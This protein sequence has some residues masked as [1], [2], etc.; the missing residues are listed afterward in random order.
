MISSLKNKLCVIAFSL[1]VIVGC[2]L[3][4]NNFAE[5]VPPKYTSD[6]SSHLTNSKWLIDP[7]NYNISKDKT[8]RENVVALF[9]PSEQDG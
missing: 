4:M 5:A 7:T 1:L 3:P 6:F 8:L 9:Y 2:I